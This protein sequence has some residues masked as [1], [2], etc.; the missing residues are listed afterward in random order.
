MD[1]EIRFHH[2]LPLL[3]RR[4]CYRGRQQLRLPLKRRTSIKDLIESLGIPH[5]EI[6]HL[7]INGQEVSFARIVEPG[8]RIEAWPLIPPLDLTRPTLL[9]PVLPGRPC[10]LVDVNV[11][12]L[13]PLLRMAGFDTACHPALADG[14]L[15]A[16]ARRENRILLTRDQGL[17][18]HRVVLF[19]HLIRAEQ[20]EAQLAEVAHLFGLGRQLRPFSRC[21]RCNGRLLGVAKQEIQDRLEPLTKRYYHSFTR[22]EQCNRIYWPGSHRERMVAL[23]NGLRP[24]SE[25]P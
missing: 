5:P 7:R 1:I 25:N 22:C 6:G 9:R 16:L 18:K 15:A 13:A 12:R 11:G 19:G 21:M 3:L 2:D 14:D 24:L 20:P 17:L 10:F 8:D 23:I 4:S